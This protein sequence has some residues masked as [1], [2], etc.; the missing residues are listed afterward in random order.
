MK[1][2]SS[3]FGDTGLQ[4]QKQSPAVLLSLF[5]G[6]KLVKHCDQISLVEYGGIVNFGF[7][8]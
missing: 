8:E 6:L 5:P 4:V 2:R 1:I 7:A 3:F